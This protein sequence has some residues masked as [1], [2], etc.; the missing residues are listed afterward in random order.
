MGQMKSTV[1]IG[2]HVEYALFS[3]DFSETCISSAPFR[4]TFISNFM[5]IRPARA[6]FHADGRTD[7]NDEASSTF[8]QFCARACKHPQIVYAYPYRAII[9]FTERPVQR[10]CS[11][12]V[13][14]AFNPLWALRY[15][16]EGRGF[17]SRWCHWNFSLTILL[18]A[19]WP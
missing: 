1:S 7:R 12:L 17:D 8:S 10:S 14:I 16:S 18:A 6:E 13:I 3:S 9:T 4:N 5:K 19:L 11:V 15:K 2:L